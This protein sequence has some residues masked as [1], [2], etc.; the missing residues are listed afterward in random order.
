MTSSEEQVIHRYTRQA[1]WVFN[2]SAGQNIPQSPPKTALY[3]HP[4]RRQC[5]R[6][7]DSAFARSHST[8]DITHSPPQAAARAG[9]VP[10]AASAPSRLEKHAH[11][12]AVWP[13]REAQKPHTDCCRVAA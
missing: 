5:W 7:P 8:Q 6:H 2:L 3:A 1:C 4:W 12:A 9:T 11:T 10:A 13:P